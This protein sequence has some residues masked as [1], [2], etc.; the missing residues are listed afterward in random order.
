M[1][2]F[3]V[4]NIQLP[5][6]LYKYPYSYGPS[7]TDS[8]IQGHNDLHSGFFLCSD[9]YNNWIFAILVP[10]CNSRSLF[11][12]ESIVYYFMEQIV[13]YNTEQIELQK[14]SN[15]TTRKFPSW[16]CPKSGHISLCPSRNGVHILWKKLNLT[17]LIKEPQFPQAKRG[18]FLMK[19]SNTLVFPQEGNNRWLNDV[20]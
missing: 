9:S 17:F 15:K 10:F 3:I 6:E 5:V 1:T 7:D 20:P 19:S 11:T 14:A 18:W 16:K 13:S 2:S 8:H 4:A 12:L